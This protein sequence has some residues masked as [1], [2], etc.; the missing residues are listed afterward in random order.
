[1]TTANSTTAFD[2]AAV[3]AGEAFNAGPAGPGRYNLSAVPVQEGGAENLGLIYSGEITLSCTLND[4][5]SLTEFLGNHTPVA[6]VM[7]SEQAADPAIKVPTRIE[8][9]A[10]GAAEVAFG[11]P[12]LR[13][14]YRLQ[15]R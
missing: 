13:S 15:A 6:G 12:L 9:G 8:T 4:T 1:M 2:N 11:Q 5:A 7:E 10:G 3:G 14:L